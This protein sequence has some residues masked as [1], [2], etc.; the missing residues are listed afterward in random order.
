MPRDTSSTINAS[1]PVAVL[2]PAG[3][4]THQ[5]ARRFFTDRA[6]FL[7]MQGHQIA[8]W[9]RNTRYSKPSTYGVLAVENIVHGFI[10][11]TFD[12]L[13]HAADVKIVGEVYLP[14]KFDLITHAKDLQSIRVVMSHEAA[15][16]QCRRHLDDLERTRGAELMRAASFST[17]AAVQAAAVDETIAA[18]GSEAAA[19][20]YNVPILRRS[21]QDHPHNA[22]RFWVLS[23]GPLPARSGKGK[24]VFLI[25][26]SDTCSSLHQLTR[27]LDDC[28]VKVNWIKPHVIPH[29]SAGQSWR[30]CYFV[31]CE[32]YLSDPGIANAYRAL[33]RTDWTALR[34]RSGRLLGSFEEDI[35]LSSM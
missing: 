29:M 1:G 15:L 12:A 19:D 25:E 22:T 13:Y 31:E 26:L 9:V 23:T 5:A 2:G 8:R 11:S 35:M 17:S 24:S 16:S 32:G 28:G 30:Y 18:L 6:D 34:G 10:G 7:P 21:Q 14:V 3:S 20:A 27:M 4:F 33:R